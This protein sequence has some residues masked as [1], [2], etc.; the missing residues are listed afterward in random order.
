MAASPCQEKH[1]TPITGH[2]CSLSFSIALHKLR[3][4][5]QRPVMVLLK[6]KKRPLHWLPGCVLVLCMWSE[7]RIRAAGLLGSLKQAQMLISS[8]QVVFTVNESWVFLDFDDLYLVSVLFFW[9]LFLCGR[10]KHVRVFCETCCPT[11]VSLFWRRK[12]SK[13]CF[14]PTAELEPLLQYTVKPSDSEQIHYCTG[15][16]WSTQVDYRD[17][18]INKN[19]NKINCHVEKTPNWNH[20]C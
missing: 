14:Y 16:N 4:K 20:W 11:S 7:A 2:K 15:V 17:C 12:H 19:L 5:R 6:E 10:E 8:R 1:G 3:A 13:S 9:P 18:W